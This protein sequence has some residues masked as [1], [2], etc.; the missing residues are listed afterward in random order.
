[1]DAIS[2]ERTL[3]QLVGSSSV[4]TAVE[5]GRTPIVSISEFA[6][7]I[8]LEGS[9]VAGIDISSKMVDLA[10]AAANNYSILTCGHLEDGLK[11][12][13]LPAR[14]Q[15]QLD[16]VTSADTFIY[17]GALDRVF[18]LLGQCVSTGGLVAFSTEHLSGAAELTAPDGFK[19]LGSGRFGHST[20]Y[21]EG[22]CASNGF[23]II[24]SESHVLRTESAEPIPGM[25]Y[26][27]ERNFSDEVASTSNISSAMV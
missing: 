11:A 10:S 16:I 5:S 20:K 27:V 15:S 17:V 4:E 2:V 22:L 24:F 18:D 21:I 6:D 14:K 3:E 1:M 23:S 12:F 9:V 13:A 7:S 25:F 19:L 26:I 8:P